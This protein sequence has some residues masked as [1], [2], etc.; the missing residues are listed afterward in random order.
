MTKKFSDISNGGIIS[1][2]TDQV[3]AVRGG[4][5]DVLVTLFAYNEVTTTSQA[6]VGNAG[7]I[8]NNAAQVVCTLPSTAS[9]GTTIKVAGK[10]AGGWKIAQNA[11]QVIHCGSV[12]T[13][14]GT[15]GFLASSSRYDF[16]ELL[17]IT[18][19]TDWVVHG[20]QG[21]ITIN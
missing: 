18:A 4:A 21:N 7:Y 11:G 10:G 5:A 2:G 8:T 1:V 16:V 15:G 20:I 6:L 19:N 17:C 14:V 3:L 12:D 9:I 13:T